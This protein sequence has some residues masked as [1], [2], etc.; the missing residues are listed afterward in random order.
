M[1][2]TNL[3]EVISSQ[4]VQLPTT[5]AAVCEHTPAFPPVIDSRV[6]LSLMQTMPDLL[7]STGPIAIVSAEALFI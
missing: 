6:D 5:N 3:N 2:T 4:F 1:S 7:F